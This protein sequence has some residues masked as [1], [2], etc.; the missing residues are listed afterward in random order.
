[1]FGDFDALFGLFDLEA[2]DIPQI[3]GPG[4][5]MRGRRLAEANAVRNPTFS[6]GGL[7]AQVQE[8]NTSYLVEIAVEPDGEIVGLCDCEVGENCAH[9]AAVLHVWAQNPQAFTPS[10]AGDMLELLKAGSPLRELLTAL[11]PRIEQ[12]LRELDALPESVR[13]ELAGLSMEELGRAPTV[14]VD[15]PSESSQEAAF[16]EFLESY[17]IQKLRAIGKRRGFRLKGVAKAEVVEQLIQ[18]LRESV[19]SPDFLAGLTPQEREVLRLLHTV[20]GIRDFLTWGEVQ[21]AWFQHRM[22]GGTE[23]LRRAL[24]GLFEYGLLFPCRAHRE[25]EQHFHWLPYLRTVRLPVLKPVVKT[26]PR[27]KRRELSHPP[28]TPPVTTSMWLLR[29]FAERETLRLAPPQPAH[30]QARLY[31]W[32]DAWVHDVEEAKRLIQQGY[33]YRFTSSDATI[34]IPAFGCMTAKEELE[35]LAQWLGADEEFADWLVSMGMALQLLKRVQGSERMLTWSEERWEEWAELTPEQQLRVLFNVWRRAMGSLAELR[36]VQQRYPELR[37]ERTIRYPDFQPEDLAREF[38]EARNFILRLLQEVP[39][40]T[41]V[42]WNAFATWAWQVDPEFLHSYWS[43]EVWGF[44]VRQGKRL[45]P[46]RRGHW[47]RAYRPV[48]A[49]FLEGPLRWLGAVEV[50]F[51]GRNLATFRLTETGAWLLRKE[52]QPAVILP[53]EPGEAPV[54]W[55]DERTLRLRHTPELGDLL[56]IVTR[57][58]TP[59][60]RP[61]TYR[62]TNASIERAFTQGITPAEIAEAFRERGAPLPEATRKQLEDLWSHFGRVHLYEN[63]TVLELADDLALREVLASTKLKDHIIH[64]FSP[65]LAVIEDSAVDALV[66]ELV[67]KGYTPKVSTQ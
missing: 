47:E 32:L 18:A 43:W 50:R 34:G 7:E 20:Y 38:M 62:L 53:V 12:R 10:S 40:D 29:T 59:T 26:Y 45:D 35:R 48:L 16:R 61:Y 60:G 28:S 63:L 14:W 8:G 25:A 27:R 58:A 23:A 9:V 49:A 17:K 15:L 30:P 51:K 4:H 57:I 67:K 55:V 21:Y 37:L 46:Q 33:G 42:D 54:T 2:E 11:D 39:T 41:W 1:M 44:S 24:D 3:C 65:R 6:S 52:G 56:R 22:K 19:R 13:S 64:Q 31:P 36:L 5:A 66:E